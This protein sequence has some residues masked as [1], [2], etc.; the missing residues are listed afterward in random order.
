MLASEIHPHLLTYPQQAKLVTPFDQW[1]PPNITIP[2]PPTDIEHTDAN[3][4][5]GLNGWAAEVAK[6]GRD[7]FGNPLV[8]LGVDHST[9]HIEEVRRARQQRLQEKSHKFR[10]V[11]LE[12]SWKLGHEEGDWTERGTCFVNVDP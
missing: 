7:S 3:V 6:R 5:N 4:R 10:Q 12:N 8:E 2:T 11:S 1:T 9:A